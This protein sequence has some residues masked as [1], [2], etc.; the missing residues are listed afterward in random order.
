MLRSNGSPFRCSQELFTQSYD[1]IDWRAH[2]SNIAPV[3]LY[4]PHP[5]ILEVTFA[6][7][8]I[9]DRIH[10]KSLRKRALDYIYQL[11]TMEDENTSY[12]CQAPVNKA[13]NMMCVSCRS[14]PPSC[15]NLPANSM[16][17]GREGPSSEAFTLHKAKLRDFLWM[18]SAGLM[19]CGTNGSQ[20]WDA[21]FIAQALYESGLAKEAQNES[22]VVKLLEWLDGCQMR[23][24]PKWGKEMSR[25]ATKGAWPFS[26]KE[27]G[28]TVSDTTA[29]G[30]KS[31][32][33]LQSLPCALFSHCFSSR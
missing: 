16:R 30:L 33:F 19:C 27:Q 7:A 26:T 31:V 4:S 2:R 20:L 1:S 21:A 28:Y 32:L 14:F 11:V 22:S 3:D 17:W 24:N 10:S 23:E 9:Y 29:E 25:H 18:S 5:A 13:M 6:I 8:G 15:A 12:Q